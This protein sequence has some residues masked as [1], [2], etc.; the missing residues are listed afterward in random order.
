MVDLAAANARGPSGNWALAPPL[1]GGRRPEIQPQGHCC[2][3]YREKGGFVKPRCLF[4][5]EKVQW[6]EKEGAIMHYKLVYPAVFLERPNRFIARCLLDGQEVRAHVKNRP[7]PG[8]FAARRHRL[9]GKGPEPPAQNRL[10]PYRG[11]KRGSAH[12]H[13][14]PSAQRFGRKGHPLRRVALRGFAPE[15]LPCAGR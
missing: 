8:T 14:L 15:P 2:S 3:L 10:F 6:A 12:Q 5:G 1:S 11:G 9:S 7:L 4:A 13:G